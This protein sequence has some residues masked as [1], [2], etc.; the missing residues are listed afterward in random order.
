[1]MELLSY[2]KRHF[3][4]VAEKLSAAEEGLCVRDFFVTG[5]LAQP[6]GTVIRLPAIGN[7][8]DLSVPDGSR[9]TYIKTIT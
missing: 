4:R 7:D 3:R 9:M 5:I 1:M 8:T 6:A 2:I